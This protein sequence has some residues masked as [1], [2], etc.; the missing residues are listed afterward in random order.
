M[1]ILAGCSM[2]FILSICLLIGLLCYFWFL[3]YL[4]FIDK[5]LHFLHGKQIQVLSQLTLNIK[6]L[7]IQRFESDIIVKPK[8]YLVSY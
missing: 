3:I 4:N 1:V 6:F 7:D 8:A 5:D 2:W